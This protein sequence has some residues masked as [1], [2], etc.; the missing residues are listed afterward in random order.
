MTLSLE[1]FSSLS[2]YYAPAAP[3]GTYNSAAYAASFHGRS[4]V[5]DGVCALRTAGMCTHP[6]YR[7]GQDLGAPSTGLPLTHLGK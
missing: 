2:I 3:G 4:G 5:T 7:Q 6:P 1:S